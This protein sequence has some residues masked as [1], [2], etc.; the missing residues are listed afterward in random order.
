MI[1]SQNIYA[2]LIIVFLLIFPS[3]ITADN[4]ISRNSFL[5]LSHSISFEI[6]GLYQDAIN[7]NKE[8]D[9]VSPPKTAGLFINYL[10]EPEVQSV[11]TSYEKGMVAKKSS[12][13]N[14]N[15]LAMHLKAFQERYTNYIKIATPFM[16]PY[17]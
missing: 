8:L 3:I 6:G 9:S 4:S 16:K 5:D 13:C 14:L 2:I 10:S 1:V 15:E 12:L 7:C 17:N 11:M